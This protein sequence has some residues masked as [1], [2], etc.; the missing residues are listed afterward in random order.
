MG[1]PGR[2][3]VVGAG[4]RGA[5]HHFGERGTTGGRGA[6]DVVGVE[7]IEHALEGAQQLVPSGHIDGELLHEAAQR[8]EILQQLPHLDI[9]EGELDLL[10]LVDRL[11][12]HG[13]LV[14][15]RRRLERVLAGDIRVRRR[16]DEHVEGVV[17]HGQP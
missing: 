8:P 3:E 5:R 12:G 9:E 10:E 16:L 14:A 6:R 4:V 2:H 13:G 17:G 7:G 1:V 15:E 11:V